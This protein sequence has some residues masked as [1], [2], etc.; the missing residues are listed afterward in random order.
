[1]IDFE[2][3]RNI[4]LN[5]MFLIGP[6]KLSTGKIYWDPRFTHI[7]MLILTKGVK[8][9]IALVPIGKEAVICAYQSLLG[10]IDT[11]SDWSFDKFTRLL[12]HRKSSR[13][14]NVMLKIKLKCF[15]HLIH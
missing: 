9:L 10:D 14:K 8:L 11:F 4:I 15:I 12:I 13:L 2:F 7:T 6:S 1:M 3:V 5:L